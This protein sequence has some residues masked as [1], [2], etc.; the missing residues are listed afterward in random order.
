M[1]H[2]YWA[3]GVC[4]SKASMVGKTV[5]ITGANSGIGKESALDIARRGARVIMACRNTDEGE[6]VATEIKEKTG[7]TKIE[8]RKLDLA[9][10]ASVRTFAE[11][12]KRTENRLDVLL[13]NA[14]VMMCPP[15]K[16]ADGFEMQLGTN[17]LGH[18]LLTNLLLDLLKS[19][20]PSRIVN[21]SSRAYL[22]GKINFDD[23]MFEK[24]YNSSAVYSQSKLANIY[25]TT[26]LAKRLEG[27]GVTANCLHP[28]V[29][30]TNLLRHFTGAG[31]KA[32]SVMA[33]PLTK[34]MMKT[35][36][37]GAQTN[38]FLSVSEEVEGVTGK[39]FADCK[40]VQLLPHAT[41][42]EVGQKL[43]EVSEKLVG[44]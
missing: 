22:R 2:S 5:I 26:E 15:M 4:T 25:F 30:D 12:I 23:L 7:S 8:V 28:G 24:K 39:Y 18:F 42:D 27:T 36:Q 13:N 29:I 43:W 14:G 44:L 9:S 21:V 17:H 41:D 40:E 16:T 1:S 10:L 35:P 32:L 6:K 11:E 3:G 38:I 37:E 33:S 20:A 34:L 31:W 19:S